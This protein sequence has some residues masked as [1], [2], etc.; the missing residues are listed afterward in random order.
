MK[1]INTHLSKYTHHNDQELEEIYRHLLE[2]KEVDKIKN[3]VLFQAKLITTK[4]T[5]KEKALYP[6]QNWEV[7]RKIKAISEVEKQ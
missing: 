1:K 2:K 7:C 3:N 4:L 6:P 5:N